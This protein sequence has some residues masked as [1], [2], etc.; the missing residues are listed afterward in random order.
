M[1]TFCYYQMLVHY[2]TLSLNAERIQKY[3]GGFGKSTWSSRPRCW[4]TRWQITD[5]KDNRFIRIT[6]NRKAPLLVNRK[7]PVLVNKK[8]ILGGIRETY[9]SRG[10]LPKILKI[11]WRSLEELVARCKG[12]SESLMPAH[13]HSALWRLQKKQ[14]PRQRHQDP[15]CWRPHNRTNQLD[16]GRPPAEEF[17]FMSQETFPDIH[18]GRKDV[19]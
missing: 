5:T 13:F 3:N 4:A 10:S 18:P 14:N 9:L 11:L 8:T 2:F 17:G 1:S 15:L 12:V 7:A 19:I 16:R 6:D